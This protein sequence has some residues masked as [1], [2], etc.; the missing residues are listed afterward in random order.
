MRHLGQLQT[1]GLGVIALVC[2]ALGCT[3]SPVVTVVDEP[4]VVAVSKP[5]RSVWRCHDGHCRRRARE[6]SGFVCIG[7]ECTQKWPR[8]PDSNE[9]DCQ[10]A[11]GPVLCRF[12]APAAGVA[13]TVVSD[14]FVCGVRLGHEGE[15]LCVDF[16]PDVPPGGGPWQCRFD[17]KQMKICLRTTAA[18]P[19]VVN[20]AP[21]CWLDADCSGGSCVAGHC[22]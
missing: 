5:E 13:V 20:R 10:A 7:E 1:V 17:E 15:R 2:C 12:H 21:D 22:Q 14:D 18:A 19:P 11:Q 6:A 4:D 16:D 8:L 3:A 9:W